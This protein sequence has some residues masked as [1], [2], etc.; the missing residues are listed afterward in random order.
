VRRKHQ[1]YDGDEHRPCDELAQKPG[2]PNPH[3]R[4]LL[5]SLSR[6]LCSR[7]VKLA[8]KFGNGSL[9]NPSIE[10][11]S[12]LKDRRPY[13]VFFSRREETKPPEATPAVGHP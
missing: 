1:S 3:T 7:V 6:D 9:R 13:D 11:W 12:Q 4:F 5:L 2:R 8:N 10:G